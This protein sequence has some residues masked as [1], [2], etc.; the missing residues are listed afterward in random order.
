VA[1]LLAA[2]AVQVAV[3]AVVLV[4]SLQDPEEQGY[5]RQYRYGW[6]MYEGRSLA[7]AY[8]AGG[9]DGAVRPVEPVREV[10]L[11]GYVHYGRGTPRRLCEVD[12]GRVWITRRALV[13]GLTPREE[14]TYPCR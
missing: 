2:V 6:Q 9:A 10:G 5:A 7:T 8:W 12:A 14:A 4:R 1:L 13:R 11:W 3:P